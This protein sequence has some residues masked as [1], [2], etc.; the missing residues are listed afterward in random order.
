MHK[1]SIY[2]IIPLFLVFVS[3]SNKYNDNNRYVKIS[4]SKGEIIVK[5]Y[6]ET[7]KHTNNFI[8]L[9]E[10]NFFDGLIF[11]RVI[12]DF[13]IQG[14]DPETR[15]AKPNVL[16]G[17][18]DA[19]YLL[20]PEI[21]DTIIHKRGVIAMAREGDDVNPNKLSSSSQFY[22]VVGK[23]YTNEQLDELQKNLNKKLRNKIEKKL[24]DSLLTESNI[25]N[26]DYLTSITKK[27]KLLTDSIFNANKIIFSDKQ[28]KTYTTIGGIPHLDGN[29]TVF[30]EVVEGLDVVKKIS[31]V[32]TDNNDRPL[33]DIKFTI[34]VIK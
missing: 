13:V 18:K 15:N 32:E 24:Y 28:R 19:G 9:S 7:P 30:G 11:H 10:E 20:E 27:V 2:I 33:K 22:I 6:N 34:S 26:T 31:E 29:Y 8:K 14:G 4:T 25:S 17:E 21:I 23:T 5:L 1:K 12:K 3:C 16:Y